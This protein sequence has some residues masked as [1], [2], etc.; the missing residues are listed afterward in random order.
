MVT[1][2]R[3]VLEFEVIALRVLLI[4]MAVVAF[5]TGYTLLT[6]PLWVPFTIAIWLSAAPMV[7]IAVLTRLPKDVAASD[8]AIQRFTRRHAA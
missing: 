7:A 2:G 4:A 1:T 3:R 5:Y 6:S 8:P